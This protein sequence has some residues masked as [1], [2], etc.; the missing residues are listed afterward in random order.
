MNTEI[1]TA[2][3][4]NDHHSFDLSAFLSHQSHLLS[5]EKDEDV[6]SST[7]LTNQLSEKE[8]VKA[9]ITLTKLVVQ[10]CRTGLY[11]RCLVTLTSQRG[12]DEYL[13]AT[14]I[15]V[16]DIVTIQSKTSSSSSGSASASSPWKDAVVYRITEKSI[17]IAVDDYPDQ[18]QQQG[19]FSITRVTNELIYQRYAASLKGLSDRGVHSTNS[20]KAIQVLYA[21]MAPSSAHPLPSVQIS[22]AGSQQRLNDAQ[23]LAIS[24]ALASHDVFC[25]HGPPG[26][27]YTDPLD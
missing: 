23:Q 4:T 12:A 8:A 25:I 19:T 26:M 17:T 6:L 20:T 16:R 1:E 15:S 13:P 7:V 27:S 5:L 2:R 18:Q 14:Q 3:D 21:G 24:R 11:G 22:P 9:G 10:Q